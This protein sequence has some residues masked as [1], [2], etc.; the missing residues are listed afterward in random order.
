MRWT[1]RK[2]D[3]N[4]RVGRNRTTPTPYFNIPDA[5]TTHQIVFMYLVT[6]DLFVSG[7]A[8]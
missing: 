7:F 8:A 5:G 6:C 1:G 3:T 2:L 4:R